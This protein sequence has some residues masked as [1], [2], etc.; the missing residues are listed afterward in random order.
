MKRIFALLIALVLCC[1]AALADSELNVKGIGTVYMDA[2]RVSAQM[3]VRLNGSDVGELQR[4]ANEIVKNICDSLEKAGL[5]EKDISTSSIYLYPQYDYSGDTE[6]IVGYTISNSLTVDTRDIDKIGEYID[7]AFAAG[8]N[9][10]DSISFSVKDDSAARKQALELA[11]QNAREKAEVIAAAAGK[12]LGEIECI[13]E[14][15]QADYYYDASRND[16]LNV[17]YAAESAEAQDVSTT[18]RAA[19]VSVSAKVEISYKLK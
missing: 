1:S 17:V 4:Q 3:G 10:F 8:A 7:V 16:G 9:T 14:D 6:N 12:E 19:Q 13:S 18:V 11:V 5:D 15:S 2:D